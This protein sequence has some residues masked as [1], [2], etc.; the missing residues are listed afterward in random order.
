MD[1][2]FVWSLSVSMRNW[3]PKSRYS[4]LRGTINIG[5]TTSEWHRSVSIDLMLLWRNIY[6]AVPLKSKNLSLVFKLTAAFFSCIHFSFPSS[7][8]CTDIAYL[9]RN[10]SQ[11][12]SV[13]SHVCFAPPLKHHGVRS[14]EQLVAVGE[15]YGGL[16]PHWEV[17]VTGAQRRPETTKLRR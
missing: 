13:S 5:F 1:D 7:F 10:H 6:T 14:K 9:L 2:G 8:M 11:A 17:K 12:H 3:S 15:A 16:H 4:T